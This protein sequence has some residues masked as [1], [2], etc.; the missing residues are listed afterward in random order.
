MIGT[1]QAFARLADLCRVIGRVHEVVEVGHA[2]GGHRREGDRR[3]CRGPMPRSGWR[4]PARRSRPCR[5]AACSLSSSSKPLAFLFAP[6][7]SRA[8]QHLREC[9]PTGAR[10]GRAPSPPPRPCG[11]A[12]D[13]ASASSRPPASAPASPAPRSP[14]SPARRGRSQGILHLGP[15]RTRRRRARRSPR[16]GSRR[17]AAS[18]RACAASRDHEP[19]DQVAGRRKI[20]NRLGDEGP[21]QGLPAPLRPPGAAP[22]TKRSTP[23]R[24]PGRVS[25]GFADLLGA[26]GKVPSLTGRSSTHLF[27]LGSSGPT[28]T[29]KCNTGHFRMAMQVS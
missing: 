16:S 1:W 19:V 29:P 23:A 5:G 26:R 8:A 9:R 3:R 4:S 7:R 15:R 11:D 2:S 28:S 20:P 21:R 22:L 12:R 25:C 13:C 17:R 10:G 24:E 27:T 14:S 18:R 6:C